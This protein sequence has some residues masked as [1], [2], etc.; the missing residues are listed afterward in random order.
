MTLT[1][2]AFAS[3]AGR[4]FGLDD[5]TP[6][7]LAQLETLGDLIR[8]PLPQT[9]LAPHQDLIVEMTDRRW[10]AA[11]EAGEIFLYGRTLGAGGSVSAFS[12]LNAPAIVGRPVPEPAAM[13]RAMFAIAI[14]AA[15]RRRPAVSPANREA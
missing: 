5:L 14:G 9:S 1:E 15:K 11:L 4:G 3:V 6:Q 12:L 10:L 13:L 8:L 2:L 7:T